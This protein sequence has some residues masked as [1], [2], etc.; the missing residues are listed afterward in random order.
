MDRRSILV[1]LGCLS[2]AATAG[3]LGPEAPGPEQTD[4]DED[5]DAGPDSPLDVWLYN[6]REEEV[7]FTVDVTADGEMAVSETVTLAAADTISTAEIVG[8]IHAG[9]TA[10]T[11]AATAG[12]QWLKIRSCYSTG[13]V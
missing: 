8:S 11:I 13:S 9:T 6:Y 4:P 2:G 7:I 1:S 10:T 5:P 12:Y 3:C